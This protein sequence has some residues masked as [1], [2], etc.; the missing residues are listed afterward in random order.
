[1]RCSFLIFIITMCFFCFPGTSMALTREGNKAMRDVVI[2]DVVRVVTPTGQ[3]E[4]SPVCGWLHNEPKSVGEYLRLTTSRRQLNISAEHLVATLKGGK[5]DF[6]KAQEVQAGT[7]IL[8]CD[9]SGAQTSTPIWGNTVQKVEKFRAE[10][11]YAPLTV[12]G[13]IVV[14]GVAAS[15]YASTRSHTAAHAAMKPMRTM[16]RHNPEKAKLEPHVGKHIAG[17]H[18]YVDVLARAAGKV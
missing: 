2:G 15:C 9:V 14:D 18:R 7:P 10:G 1:L 5:I 12:A 6:V 3:A 4:W 13:T 11:I 17:A 8:E 16:Y